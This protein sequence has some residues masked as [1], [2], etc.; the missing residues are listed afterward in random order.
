MKVCPILREAVSWKLGGDVGSLRDELAK[1]KLAKEVL[2][3]PCGVVHGHQ[4][5]C[6]QSEVF[7]M[8]SKKRGSGKFV[9]FWDPAG[10]GQTQS[11]ATLY[12]SSG[13]DV[14]NLTGDDEDRDIEMGDSTGVTV[15]LSGGISL[16][17]KEISRI[18]HWW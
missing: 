12:N 15:S 9:Y 1:L 4:G 7:K 2:F 18:K 11:A 16:G 6:L 8:Q 3:C 5:A 17:R 14:V 10:Y 13:G